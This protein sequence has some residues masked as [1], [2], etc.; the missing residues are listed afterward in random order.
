MIL[1]K[2]P[3]R[4]GTIDSHE[5]IFC[6]FRPR[7]SDNSDDCSGSNIDNYWS[8][9][10]RSQKKIDFLKVEV[11]IFKSTEISVFLMLAFLFGVYKNLENRS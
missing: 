4:Q 9:V 11:K 8:G 6:L 2:I 10:L 1:R 7:K 5:I 3:L